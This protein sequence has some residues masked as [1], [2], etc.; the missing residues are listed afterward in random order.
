MLVYK[1][2][3]APLFEDTVWPF[4]SRVLNIC[5]VRGGHKYQGLYKYV[6]EFSVI[7]KYGYC[8]EDT[9]CYLAAIK[10]YE[11]KT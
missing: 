2:T 11:R 9:E 4:I 6:T 5:F 3:I 8:T 10:G 7:Y 1:K